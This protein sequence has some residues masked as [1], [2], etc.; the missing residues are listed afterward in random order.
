MNWRRIGWSAL[1]IAILA[2]ALLLAAR[3]PRTLTI[4]GIAAFIAFG[5]QP[6]VSQLERRRIPRPIGVAIVFVVLI[7]LVVIGAIVIVPM[8][9]VQATALAANAPTYALAAHRWTLDVQ[10]SLQMHFPWLHIPT[11]SFDISHFGGKRLA[12]LAGIGLSSLGTI[13]LN[14]ATAV[15]IAITA[16]ILSIFFLLNDRQIAHGFVALFPAG[17]RGTALRLVAE[18]T[19]VFGSYI[20][21]QVIVSTITGIVVA[22]GSAVVGF[23]FPVILGIITAVAYA[24]PILGMLIA[25]ILAALLCAP[26]GWAVVLWVQAIMFAMARISDNILVPKIMGNSVGVPPIGV[27]F[28]VIAGGELFGLPGLL[29]GIPAAALAKILWRYFVAPYLNPPGDEAT[30]RE[31]TSSAER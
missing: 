13:L 16:V 3:I 26:Q 5:L 10:T 8:T 19:S 25:Q 20:S 12:L 15:F 11:S 28:A 21:G 2:A 7:A 14:T 17:R 9:I 4:F 6:I 18:V 31:L 24:I 29:L 23:K 22:V 30:G 1:G 27:M